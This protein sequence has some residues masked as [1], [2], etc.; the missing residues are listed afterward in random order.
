MKHR[1]LSL[2]LPIALLASCTTSKEVLYFQDAELNRAEPVQ[3]TTDIVLQ[4]GD[5]ISIIVASKDPQLAV[6]FN[7]PRVQQQLGSANSGVSSGNGNT[8]GYTL[9]KAGEIDFPILGKLRVGG[10]SRTQ[11]AEMVK[12]KLISGRLI[13]DP[14]VT[15]EFMN[16]TYAVMGEVAAPGRYGIGKDRVTLLE[17]LSQAGD[18]TIY[19]KRDGIEVIR[20]EN[21]ERR[22]Y[23]VDIRSKSL[24]DSPVYYLKQNDVVYVQPNKVR[25]GQS[26]VND[27]NL[28]SVGMWMSIASFV[29]SMCVL[30]FR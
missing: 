19:G 16:L 28:R 21:G 7:L 5:Q 30:I 11:V 29:S 25:A 10:L 27:N 15:V 23:R 1:F 20:E 6:L 14:V 3:A 13:N 2:L 24:F 9:D 18:L 4:P 8:S 12:E 26:S 17:A 22:T